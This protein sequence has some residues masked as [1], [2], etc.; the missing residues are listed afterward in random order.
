MNQT[1]GEQSIGRR[2]PVNWPARSPDLSPLDFW[3]LEHVN[4]LVHSASIS[5]LQILQQRVE[6]ACQ[7]IGVKPEIFDRVG[8]TVTRRAD[9]CLELNGNHIERLL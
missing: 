5:N 4:I 8:I 6:N 2:D 7:E 3:L 9:S 1:F